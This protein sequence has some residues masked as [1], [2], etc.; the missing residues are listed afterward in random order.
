MP[1]GFSREQR[2]TRLRSAS[3][4]VGLL[5]TRGPASEKYKWKLAAVLREAFR[6][7]C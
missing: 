2:L 1:A 6:H 7:R 4:C 3:S 5:G